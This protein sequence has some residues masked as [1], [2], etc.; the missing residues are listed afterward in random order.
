M[1]GQIGAGGFPA[2]NFSDAD[3]QFLIETVP[4]LANSPGGNGMI[5]E[6]MKRTETLKVENAKAY[7]H[8]R[9]NAPKG[10]SFYDFEN[11]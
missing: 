11:E 1:V 6:A 10:S 9:S 5:L 2:N 3:R 4:A 7:R 8:W